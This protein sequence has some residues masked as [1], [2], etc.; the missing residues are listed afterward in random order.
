MKLFTELSYLLW[1]KQTASSYLRD[2][3]SCYNDTKMIQ[4]QQRS[5]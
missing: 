3:N 1:N 5:Q 4:K 2:C